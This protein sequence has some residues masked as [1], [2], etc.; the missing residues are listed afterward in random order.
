M[1]ATIGGL[2]LS[3]AGSIFGANASKRAAE[4]KR[5][6]LDRMERQA[7]DEYNNTLGDGTQTAAQQTADTNTRRLALDQLAQIDANNVVKNG[8]GV[9]RAQALEAINDAVAQQQGA[10]AV[11]QQQRVDA[12]RQ[13][14]QATKREIAGQRMGIEQARAEQSAQAGAQVAQ[15]GM[16]IAA[17]EALGKLDKGSA[18]QSTQST[19]GS[20][21]AGTSKPAAGAKLF[22][23]PAPLTPDIG[24]SIDSLKGKPISIKGHYDTYDQQR[25]KNKFF[26]MLK[27]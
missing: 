5:L 10:A 19:G 4:R 13:Q 6:Y 23:K 27:L 2:A 1:W 18:Q 26:G 20:A 12:A 25:M 21:G 24:K 16:Q 17:A 11:A 14:L 9:E 8:T 3:A 7:Q 15:A 22:D